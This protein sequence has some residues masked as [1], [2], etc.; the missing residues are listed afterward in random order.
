MLVMGVST[1]SCL[2][3]CFLCYKERTFC[4]PMSRPSTGCRP[5]SETKA[6]SSLLVVQ[7]CPLWW[8]EQQCLFDALHDSLLL[9]THPLSVWVT[10]RQAKDWM[11]LFIPSFRE[12]EQV[13]PS[14]E[15]WS[16][17]LWSQRGLY[18]SVCVLWN[19]EMALWLMHVFA[20]WAT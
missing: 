8:R 14:D 7:S 19:L 1:K 3:N 2:T 4:W 5:R 11:V 15:D 13:F 9:W 6:F 18:T 20:L 10:S 12:I 16:K 17:I